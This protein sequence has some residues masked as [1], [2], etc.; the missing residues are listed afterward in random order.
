MKN[1]KANWS[2]LIYQN[3]RVTGLKLTKIVLLKIQVELK[4]GILIKNRRK[5]LTGNDFFNY[6]LF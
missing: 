6:I 2:Y 4:G 5:P 3:K 1:G